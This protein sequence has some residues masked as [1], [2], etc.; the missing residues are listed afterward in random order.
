MNILICGAGE[1]GR[2]AA[3]VLGADG[4]NITIIDKSAQK[5]YALEDVMDVRTM[6]GD[7]AHA[8]AL[9]EAGCADADVFIAAADID[10]INLM[11]ASIASGL[12]A[13]R[14]IAR[15]QHSV[16]FEGKGIDYKTHLGIDNLVCPDHST[17]LAIARTLR[18]PGALAVERFARGRIEMQ[19]LSVGPDAQA[20]SKPLMEL[21]LPQSLR[22]A[23]VERNDTTF[24]PHAQT[25]IEQGDIVTLIGDTDTLNKV[26][27]SF[28]TE[29]YR[30]KRVMIIGGSSL[31]VWLCR[32]LH[33]RSYSVRLFETDQDRAEELSN[34]LDWVT[35]LRVDPLDPDTMTLERIDQA[36][37]FIAATESEE[38]NILAAARA[39]SM[40]AA[41]S[42]AVLHR[43][44][45]MNLVE[46]VGID[47]AFSPPEAAVWEIK[48]LL[49]EGPIRRLGELAVGIAYVYEIR[50]PKDGNG[51][52]GKPLKEV[53][54]PVGVMIAAIQRGE[55][56]RVPGG[57]DSI[58]PGDTVVAIGPEGI[59]KDLRK[60]FGIKH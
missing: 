16:Y 44:M 7:G 18:S 17:A 23:A 31:S 58:S 3:E 40:G 35:V 54:F 37:A 36:D 27:K 15:V 4:H 13:G 20:I 21:N 50:V 46:H 45:Y 42:L 33:S 26:R 29:S 22:L 59:D 5:L 24:I 34:K 55:E 47:R 9:E 38:Q 30:R 51:V 25:T 10:E 11:A 48:Q 49:D 57:D 41:N 60:S 19:Q 28:H 39:K 2:H 6:L 56:V 12:G 53:K 8:S 14:T 43:D 32:A 1:V 52:V